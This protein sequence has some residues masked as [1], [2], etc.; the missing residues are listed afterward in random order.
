MAT[1]C[2]RV[3][4]FQFF[5]N[6][7]ENRWYV[8]V[9]G[10][11][12]KALSALYAQGC[13]L[14][15]SDGQDATQPCSIHELCFVCIA[16]P[17]TGCCTIRNRVE[18]SPLRTG[19]TVP[20]ACT[21]YFHQFTVLPLYFFYQL[22]FSFSQRIW[23]CFVCYCK[24]LFNMCFLIHPGED[25]RDLR[26]VPYPAKSPFCSGPLRRSLIPDLFHGRRHGAC[27]GSLR[28]GAP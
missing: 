20:A 24:I 13:K 3:R 28:G 10:T 22:Q 23:V 16:G 9:L 6:G 19:H 8:K 12:F 27:R 25:N 7:F 15:F 17:C 14:G 11:F 5:Y 1:L 21:A 2:S 4:S 18:Y 26:V